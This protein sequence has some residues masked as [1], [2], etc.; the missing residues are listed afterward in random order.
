MRN[1]YQNTEMALPAL[2]C[3]GWIFLQS[4]MCLMKRAAWLKSV[5]QQY[6]AA[7][8]VLF[9]AFL[10]RVQCENC[11]VVCFDLV[12]YLLAI[13]T[14]HLLN[15]TGKAVLCLCRFCW[16]VRKAE[17]SICA[18]R[19]GSLNADR[20]AAVDLGQIVFAY[21]AFLHR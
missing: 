2:S 3:W 18:L 9:N 20:F 13:G 8:W 1:G 19:T 10:C 6:Y 14:G 15:K 11:S 7:L 12:G 4:K 17:C 16:R 21:T 5:H